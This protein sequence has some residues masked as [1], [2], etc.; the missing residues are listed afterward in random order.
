MLVQLGTEYQVLVA[1]KLYSILIIV[2]YFNCDFKVFNKK[3]VD[4]VVKFQFICVGDCSVGKSSV[5]NF[6]KNVYFNP[7]E[8][9]PTPGLGLVETRV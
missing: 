4:K 3:K 2:I 5:L 9:I 8:T 7:E 6:Y 1:I